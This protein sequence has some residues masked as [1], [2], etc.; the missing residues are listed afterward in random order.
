MQI[1]VAAIVSVVFLFKGN[2]NNWK[3]PWLVLHNSFLKHFWSII[4][5]CYLNLV[6]YLRSV[7]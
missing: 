2:L 5:N 3:I 4:R 7:R 1:H 6:I